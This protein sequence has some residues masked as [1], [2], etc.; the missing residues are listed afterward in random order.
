MVTDRLQRKLIFEYGRF[1]AASAVIPNDNNKKG[2]ISMKKSKRM[3]SMILAVI[4]LSMT[5]IGVNAHDELPAEEIDTTEIAVESVETEATGDS[6]LLEEVEPSVS[7]IEMQSKEGETE[8]EEEELQP[9][10]ANR[11][12]VNCVQ[13]IGYSGDSYSIMIYQSGMV[14]ASAGNYSISKAYNNSN[15]N[16]PVMEYFNAVSAMQ[17]FFY[18][19][20]HRMK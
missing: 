3:I 19:C 18:L 20:C 16:D 6:E 5:A 7:E 1:H 8:V 14:T 9:Q 13:A 12:I 4:M 2:E 15:D 11:S 17:S 10:R